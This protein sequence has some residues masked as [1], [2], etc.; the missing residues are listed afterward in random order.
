MLIFMTD[1]FLKNVIIKIAFYF[2]IFEVFVLPKE[3]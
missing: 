2:F 1:T 3:I